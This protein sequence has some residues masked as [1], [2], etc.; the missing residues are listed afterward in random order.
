MVVELMLIALIL[1]LCIIADKFS[2][3][4]KRIYPVRTA[5]A[6][7]RHTACRIYGGFAGRIKV[8]QPLCFFT[9][10]TGADTA[11]VGG[12]GTDYTFFK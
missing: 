9:P 3:K 12:K 5:P 7:K 6:C 8:R 1:V 4:E 11:E 2:G 10:F